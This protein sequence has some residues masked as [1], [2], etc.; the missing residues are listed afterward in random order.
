MSF[1]NPIL[2][3]RL[4]FFAVQPDSPRRRYSYFSCGVS[5]GFPSPAG[6]YIQKTLDLNELLVQHPAST[7]FVRVKGTSMTDAGL[8]DGDLLI[9][10]RSLQARHRDIVLAILNGD[11]T[12]K[13]FLKTKSG[14]FLKPE[15][16]SF[17][18]ISITEEMDFEVWGV[19]TDIVHKVR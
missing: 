7:F 5:A 17:A 10:D 12:V 4:Q 3:P 8:N 6:D 11:F 16:P 9:I 13:R 2:T 19:V 1:P 15:N 14:I 18:P